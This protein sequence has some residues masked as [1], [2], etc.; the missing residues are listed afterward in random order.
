MRPLTSGIVLLL[1]SVTRLRGAILNVCVA[2]LEITR[3]RGGALNC[4]I[5]NVF[6]CLESRN[7]IIGSE[8]LGGSLCL[9]ELGQ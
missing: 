5:S 9:E 8:S 4:E 3:F 1:H 2:I 6:S 7:R